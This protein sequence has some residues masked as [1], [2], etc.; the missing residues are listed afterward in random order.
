MYIFIIYVFIYLFI[1]TIIITIITL[2]IITIIIY[3]YY[4]YIIIASPIK[5]NQEN[6]YLNWLCFQICGMFEH[7]N[8]ESPFPIRNRRP[9][10]SRHGRSV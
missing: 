1:I 5:K 6:D 7:Q 8:R 3:Y 10:A 4:I 9:T 2:I